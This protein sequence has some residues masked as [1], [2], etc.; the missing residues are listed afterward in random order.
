MQTCFDNNLWKIQRNTKRH[1]VKYKGFSCLRKA[2]ALI[3][4]YGF[5]VI[6]VLLLLNFAMKANIYK[7]VYSLILFMLL[8]GFC[9]IA[10]KSI[11]EF[12]FV[13]IRFNFN[14]RF[15]A[16]S[17]S[18]S[19][20][21]ERLVFKKSCLDNVYCLFVVHP[22]VLDDKTGELLKIKIWSSDDSSE[23]DKVYDYLVSEYKKG[24]AGK[25]EE[26]EYFSSYNKRK[27]ITKEKIIVSKDKIR[28][29][30]DQQNDD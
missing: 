14:D 18:D 2:A 27:T 5:L 22:N 7:S 15:I 12:M 25:P 4:G 6:V 29:V 9:Y 11:Y 21:Y 10:V 19:F 24:M 26:H 3:A 17:H 8:L 13:V 28:E 30:Q 16:R 23:T 1:Y 20:P